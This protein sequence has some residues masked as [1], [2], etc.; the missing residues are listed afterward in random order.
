ME[1]KEHE[2]N[3][4][5]TFNKLKSSQEMNKECIVNCELLR[6]LENSTM[7]MVGSEIE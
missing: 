1:K 2:T 7:K 5:K 4:K 3:E 6:I